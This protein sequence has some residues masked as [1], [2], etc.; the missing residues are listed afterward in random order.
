[1][2]ILS[3]S[4]TS[5]LSGPQKLAVNTIGFIETFRN[6]SIGKFGE[7]TAISLGSRLSASRGK[8]ESTEIAF[9]EIMESVLAYF[10]PGLLANQIFGK[11]FHH[12]GKF[13]DP[14]L[15]THSLTDLNKVGGKALVQKALP[16]R[17]AV[18]LSS[19]VLAAICGEYILLFLKNLMTLKVYQTGNFNHIANLNT[20]SAKK[21]T[22]A[23]TNDA[24]KQKA[25]KR[26]KQL[27]AIGGGLLISSMAM[28]QFSGFKKAIAHLAKGYTLDSQLKP[29]NF[30]TKIINALDFDYSGKKAAMKFPAHL[31]L[32][33]SVAFLG[34]LDSARNKLERQEVATRL[35]LIMGYMLV[36]QTLI[37]KLLNKF[38]FKN[39]EIHQGT[40][41]H[42]LQS[43]TSK[44]KDPL[45]QVLKAQ[46]VLP[47]KLLATL[48]PYI[49][50]GGIVSFG[51]ATL[52]KLMTQKRFNLQK[53]TQQIQQVLQLFKNNADQP[54]KSQSA[55]FH[56]LDYQQMAY[57][58]N[59]NLTTENNPIT[60]KKPTNIQTHLGKAKPPRI[61]SG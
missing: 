22:Q 20:I 51:I 55:L 25:H 45:Q 60:A 43:L 33:M 48:L 11:L 49:I 19:V 2:S 38:I 61:S 56:I 27:L 18:L 30:G 37:S 13:N 24:V 34:Y 50:G 52:S 9:A 6:R 23:T 7:D 28:V 17:L 1:M 58:P 59:R 14:R 35:P 3:S 44:N 42:Y 29:R 54:L 41:N 21:D 12:L 36:G 32:Y 31:A 10:V 53:Q 4:L 47:Q 46:K 39:P 16:H 40:L 15:L 57:R 8:T 5:G 26:I